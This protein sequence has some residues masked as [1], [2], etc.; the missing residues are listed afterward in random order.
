MELAPS[1]HDTLTTLANSKSSLDR[2]AEL[3]AAI[4]TESFPP[5]APAKTPVKIKIKIKPSSPKPLA[6]SWKWTYEDSEEFSQTSKDVQMLITDLRDWHDLTCTDRTCF[7]GLVNRLTKAHSGT[8]IRLS[9]KREGRKVLIEDCSP[10]TS[11][12]I[13]IECL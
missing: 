7:D 2:L 9:I 12:E 13:S 10:E 11:P 5:P 4:P 1:F 6:S 8:K 3:L